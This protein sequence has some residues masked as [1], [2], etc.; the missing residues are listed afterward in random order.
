MAVD[1]KRNATV[2]ESEENVPKK[3]TSEELR[4]DVKRSTLVA[5]I[6]FIAVWLIVWLIA[7]EGG[8]FGPSGNNMGEELEN[9]PQKT[10]PPF[11]PQ[12]Y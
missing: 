8:A 9:S 7:Y 11:A 2:R 10:L 4:R 12:G 1:K 6:V 3:Q 5:S